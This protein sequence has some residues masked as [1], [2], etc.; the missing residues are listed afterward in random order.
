MLA[1][2]MNFTF[3]EYSLAAI[4][5]TLKELHLQNCQVKQ[6]RPLYYLENI[7]FLNL[8]DNQISDF[9]EQICPIL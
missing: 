1:P 8:K 3:D 5:G 2:E 7:E 4:S 9:D 6:P